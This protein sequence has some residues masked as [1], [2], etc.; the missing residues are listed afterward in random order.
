M[1]GLSYEVVDMAQAHST[2]PPADKRIVTLDAYL[3][4]Y[5]EDYEVIDGRLVG[6]TPQY[7]QRSNVRHTLYHHLSGFLGRQVLRRVFMVVAFTLD[8]DRVT[9][10]LTTALAP[11]LALIS[12][13]NARRQ[14]QEFDDVD[15]FC[16][17]PDLAVEIVSPED[18]YSQIHR[19]VK[20]YL[21]Y[22][23][24]LVW[25]IDP[26]NREVHI[27]TPGRP[28]G[29]VLR[30]PDVLSLGCILPGWSMPIQSLLDDRL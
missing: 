6:V 8:F 9:G 5:I 7:V 12:E 19:K 15:A 25:V 1:H 27:H 11:D 3:G 21:T 16:V 30:E 22:G 29:T 23:V 18:G 14:K 24:K 28:D 20:L 13:E 4:G 2:A 17:P 26:S 10:L